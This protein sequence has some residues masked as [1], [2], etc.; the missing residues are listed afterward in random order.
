MSI[1]AK[2]EILK[3]LAHNDAVQWYNYHCWITNVAISLLIIKLS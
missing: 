3:R 2:I 1:N